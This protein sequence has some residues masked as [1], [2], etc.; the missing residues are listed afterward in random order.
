MVRDSI[1][2]GGV[3]K[4]HI[5]LTDGSEIVVQESN[6]LRRTALAPGQT[7]QVSWSIVDCVALPGP[8]PFAS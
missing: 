4:H 6:H 8:L 3:V 1:V 2:L 7:V 5:T